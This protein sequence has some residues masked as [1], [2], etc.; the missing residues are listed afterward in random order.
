MIDFM[1]ST[2]IRRVTAPATLPVTLAQAKAHLRVDHS[3]ED[4]LITALIS[5][6]VEHF[7]GV[8]ILGRA[9]VTQSWA[10]C[11]DAVST[12]AR[13]G[14][15]PFLSLT[16]V[17]YYDTDNASQTATLADF[18][19]WILGDYVLAKPIPGASWPATYSR[20]DA[21]KIT[22][23]A[24]FGDADDVPTTIKQAILLTVAH[25][26]EHRMAVDDT[27]MVELPM[28]VDALIGAERVGW[29][30]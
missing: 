10:E 11:F 6:A 25:W 5:A 13:L 8:G 9:M 18:E 14:M 28:A 19:T 12:V 16:S 21:I 15:G 4:D 27:K 24:G 22:Y 26:Y 20:P 30:G 1:S 7:D 2:S 3:D 17:Q 29:Y 23:Q